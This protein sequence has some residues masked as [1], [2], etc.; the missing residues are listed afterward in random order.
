MTITEQLKRQV[1][2]QARKAVERLPLVAG[3]VH[4]DA[5]WRYRVGA[6]ARTVGDHECTWMP[7]GYA[8]L[9]ISEAHPRPATVM[10]G[11][12]RLCSAVRSRV[13]EGRWVP[14]EIGELINVNHGPA[15][16]LVRTPDF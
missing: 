16:M 3:M 9:P 6:A 5:R 8:S 15:I 14:N 7:G 4:R 10:I 11:R 12:C 1:K 2:R 13:L